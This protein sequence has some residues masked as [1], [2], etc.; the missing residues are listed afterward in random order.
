MSSGNQRRYR[1]PVACTYR[2]RLSLLRS[3]LR[4][5]F[6]NSPHSSGSVRAIFHFGKRGETSGLR[7][8]KSEPPRVRRPPDA[9]ELEIETVLNTNRN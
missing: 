9:G 2:E 8:D 3:S 6:I 4:V 7:D 5:P 1:T